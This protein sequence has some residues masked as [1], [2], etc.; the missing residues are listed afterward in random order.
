MA[1]S[2]FKRVTA[3]QP[4]LMTF[5]SLLSQFNESPVRTADKSATRLEGGGRASAGGV[6]SSE[7]VVF[8]AS[9]RDAEKRST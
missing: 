7:T 5:Q 3:V 2:S 4:T 6:F 9:D 8:S 1:F